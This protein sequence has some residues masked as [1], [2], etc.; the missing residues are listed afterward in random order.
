MQKRQVNVPEIDGVVLKVTD[1]FIEVVRNAVNGTVKDFEIYSNAVMGIGK[2]IEIY[3]NVEKIQIM[4]LKLISI[5]KMVQ[6]I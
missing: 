5:Q 6:V 2:D 1:N 3:S 4:F